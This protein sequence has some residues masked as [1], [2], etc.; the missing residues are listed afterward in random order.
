MVTNICVVGATGKFGRSIISQN[1]PN[2]RIS[3]AV[4]SDS[5]RFLSVPLNELGAPG[6]EVIVQGASN[7]EAVAAHSDVVLFVSKPEADL[8]NVPK[9]VSLHKPIVM[10]T[11]GFTTTQSEQLNSYLRRI[12][13]IVA[14]NFSL[15]AN[16]LFQIT[17]LLSQFNG[18]YDYSIIEYHHKLKKDAPSGTAKSIRQVLNRNGAFP[19][20]ITDRT[21]EPIRMQNQIEVLAVRGGGTPGIH[22]LIL[23]GE[24]D[25]IRVEHTAFSRAAAASGALVACEWIVSQEKPGIY[26]M[27]DVLQ[28]R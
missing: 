21:N 14:P 9:I 10:G 13:S 5:S 25:M 16:I 7:L 24:Y 19:I 22:Q 26:T 3:G 15:G 12:P 18:L 17:K 8:A 27:D 6:S 2:I 20:T 11:T 1:N 4:S 23:S 28:L